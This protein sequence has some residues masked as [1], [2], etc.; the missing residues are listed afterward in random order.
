MVAKGILCPMI[1]PCRDTKVDLEASRKLIRHIISKGAAGIFG[2]GS[3]GSFPI[4]SA[5]EHFKFLESARD[6]VDARHTF[7]ADIS[8]N[9][10]EET[11]E[12]G[13]MVVG[14]G[15]DA[16]VLNTPYYIPMEQDS[17]YA[18]FDRLLGKLDSDVLLYNIPQFSGNAISVET[19][20]KLAAQHS[21]LVGIKESSG[22][23]NNIM[24]FLDGMPKGFAVF[25][26]QDNFLLSSLEYG[27]TGGI[28]GT[29]NFSDIAVK[30]YEAF[31]AGKTGQARALQKKL[32]ALK[33]AASIVP[34]PVGPAYLAS[35][36]VLGSE[37][38]YLH[39][40]IRDITKAKKAELY[41]AYRKAL[42]A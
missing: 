37:S 17:L 5:E 20:K 2:A 25:Q 29:T 41:S 38:T 34:F 4:L 30:V 3:N 21:N 22:I 24:A 9:N 14:I 11:L 32:T 6:V 31:A 27:A 7:F 19:V 33:N 26:G 16:V 10:Y 23:F 28:C 1:T 8:R 42:K 36:L 18:Y 35:K 15:P 39:F 40:P 13:R 12:M